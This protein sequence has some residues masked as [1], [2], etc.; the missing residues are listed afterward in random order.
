MNAKKTVHRVVQGDCL[1]VMKKIPT[2]SIDFICADFPYNISNNPWLTMR[3]DKIVKA[4][5]GEWDKWD[6]PALYLD[7]VFQVCNEY[8]RI[9]K[10]NA[11]M[12]LFFGYRY[13]GWI[14]F[15]LEKRGLF[16]FRTPIVFNKTNPMLHITKKW[17]RSCFEQ[18]MW[19]VNDE[20]KFSRPKTFNFLGQAKM[21]NVLNYKIGKEGNKQ[22]KHP[23]EKPEFLIGGLVEIFTNPWDL[24]LDN[25]AG[26]GTT[27]VASYKKGRSCIS[28][29]KEDSFIEMIKARQARA[30]R[31]GS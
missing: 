20:G 14:A 29:E 23:T 1:E 22:S 10:P 17:F 24:V 21:K 27:G 3:W 4:D 30:Q 2:N 16:T 28:I 18:G 8:Q 5:F 31:R 25:F 11:S 26:S 19:L 15:E 13:A 6:T 7:F 12:V 9:L